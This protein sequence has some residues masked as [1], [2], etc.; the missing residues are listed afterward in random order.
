MLRE[1]PE[2]IRGEDVILRVDHNVPVSRAGKVSDHERIDR[3][4]QFL[5]RLSSLGC[6][7]LLLTHWGYPNGIR[8]ARLSTRPLADYVARRLQ[9]PVVFCDS[10]APGSLASPMSRLRPG[11]ILYAENVRFLGA[12]EDNAIELA[13]GWSRLGALYV[14]DALSVSHRPHASVAQLPYLL[15]SFAGPNLLAECEALGRMLDSANQPRTVVLGGAKISQKLESVAALADRFD[16]VILVGLT[17]LCVAKTCTPGR[18]RLSDVVR[19]QAESALKAIAAAN[20]KVLLPRDWI[21]RLEGQAASSATND[22]ASID[23]VLDIGPET[24][25]ALDAALRNCRA[26]FW[27]GPL[28]RYEEAGG[29]AGTIS[30]TRML[31]ARGKHALLTMA[32]GGDTLAA[33]KATGEAAAFN[34]LSPAGGAALEYLA[35]GERLPG[36][37][38]LSVDNAAHG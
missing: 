4:L 21:V 22:P 6:R 34:H 17:G 25:G 9:L 13:R 30:F 14:N 2:T 37:W 31:A 33:L 19:V 15:P 8:D 38:P 26:V 32:A 36:L 18:L 5:K 29:L 16:R 35:H 24:L 11:E 3:S 1:L 10:A 20:C 7:V 23:E 12:E 28:G 27:N